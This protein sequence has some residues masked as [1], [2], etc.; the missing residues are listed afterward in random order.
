MI[1]NQFQLPVDDNWSCSHYEHEGYSEQ[2]DGNTGQFDST[3]SLVHFVLPYII[4]V[5]NLQDDGN[6]TQNQYD[7][8]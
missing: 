3:F 5:D 2:C 4:R 7:E 6:T 8:R 1:N